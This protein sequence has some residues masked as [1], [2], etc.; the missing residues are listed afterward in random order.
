M[1]GNN[2]KLTMFAMW[3]PPSV[4]ILL[5]RERGRWY[6]RISTTHTDTGISTTYTN[7]CIRLTP[8]NMLPISYEDEYESW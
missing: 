7:T 2:T 1:S 3:L 8:S 4:P 6:L 5:P